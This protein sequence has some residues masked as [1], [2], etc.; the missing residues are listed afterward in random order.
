MRNTLLCATSALALSAGALSAQENQHTWHGPYVS[1]Q[2]GLTQHSATYE[3]VDYDWYGS[4]FDLLSQGGSA[5]IGLGY[6]FQSQNTLM[7]VQADVSALS[8]S[9]ETIFASDVQIQNDLDVLVKL[10]GRVGHAVDNTVIYASAG[11]AYANFERSWTE[12][13]DVSDSWPDLGDEKL[14]VALGFGIERAINER[15][16]VSGAFTSSLFGENTSVNENDFPL[17]INDKIDELTFAVNYKLGNVGNAADSVS[18]AGSPASFAG[19]YGGARIGGGFA[20]IATSDIEYDEHGG[21]YEIGNTGGLAAISGGYNWQLGAT[22]VGVET[23]LTFSDLAESYEV[24]SVLAETAMEQSASI[25]TRAGMAVGDTMLY[26]LG[27]ITAADVESMNGGDTSGTYT[28]LTVGAGV[29]QFFT[30][31]MSW[32]AE[33]TYTLFDGQGDADTTDNGYYSTADLTTLAAGVNY[34]FGAQPRKTGSGAMAATHDWSGGYY[35]AD[36]AALANVGSVQDSDYYDFG[37]SFDVVSLGAG[38]GG[39]AGYNWQNGSFVYGALLDI[40]AYSN[41][42]SQTADSYREIASS[43]AAMGTLRARA[44]IASGNSLLYTTAGLGMVQSDLSYEYL[45]TPNASSFDLSKTRLG[46]VVGLGLEHTLSDQMSFKVETLYFSS[47]AG[48]YA[49]DP[50]QTCGG[51]DGFD[52]GDCEMTGQDSNASVKAGLSFKF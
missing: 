39:H 22:V 46:V 42:E 51:P 35:G 50:V 1:S 5:G 13:N 6:N 18:L 25:R 27:G 28:G 17:R 38:L 45:P 34:Y 44:G 11:L 4:T 26:V 23:Q 21:T 33:G 10:Q 3:D 20:D 37:G 29:E 2:I 15:F 12:F 49:Q 19:A 30:D 41:D 40:A 47:D 48:D 31:R 52:G 9:E 43:I 16:S 8:N 32:T 36:L 7:G 24:D 14:G